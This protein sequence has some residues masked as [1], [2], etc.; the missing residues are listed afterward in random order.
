MLLVLRSLWE[1]QA[2]SVVVEGEGVA[3]A[4][5][6]GTG[7]VLITRSAR[8]GVPKRRRK[9]RSRQR[10][11]WTPVRMPVPVPVNVQF[12]GQGVSANAQIGNGSVLIAVE[13]TDIEVISLLMAA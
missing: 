9:P 2:G 7:D 12:T 13:L 11:Y 6:I 10:D 3:A 5:A 8:G 4:P 1:Q